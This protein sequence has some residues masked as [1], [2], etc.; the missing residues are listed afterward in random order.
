[1]HVELHAHDG[2]AE[3]SEH[4]AMA[5]IVDDEPDEYCGREE[6]VQ[7]GDRRSTDGRAVRRI[8]RAREI[9]LFLWSSHPM[10]PS[11]L[12]SK[13]KDRHGGGLFKTENDKCY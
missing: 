5:D 9:R 13:Q 1:M 12:L 6:G 11:E 8:E 10:H 2:T 3:V 4:G 7:G